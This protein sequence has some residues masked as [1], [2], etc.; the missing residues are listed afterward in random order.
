MNNFTEKLNQFAALFEKEQIQGL[1]RRGLSCQSNLDNHKV[2]IKS[3][4][5][6]TKVDIGT[7]GRFMVENETGN[8][9]GIKGYGVI[10]KGHYYGNLET[11]TEYDWSDYYP[12][13]KIAPVGTQGC[14]NPIGHGAPKLTFAP[15]PS[16]LK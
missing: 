15:N 13:H 11:T 10:H 1:H 3:G 7:S 16:L 8:I 6:Y 5:K 9:F 14:G 12:H 4:K 2:S